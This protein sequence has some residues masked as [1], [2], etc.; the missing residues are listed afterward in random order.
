MR[1]SPFI[2][3]RF[4]SPEVAAGSR[5]W[6]GL[7]DLG[8]DDVDVDGEQAALFD[9]CHDGLHHRVAIAIGDGQHGVLHHVGALLV[10]LLELEGVE[11]GLVVV[12]APDVMDAAFAADQHLIDVEGRPR[13]GIVRPHIAFLMAAHAHAAAARAVRH[14][15]YASATF[16]SAALVR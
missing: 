13:S 11:R 6:A 1:R 10:G 8:R 7:A 9:C 14:C 3:V 2:E 12:A 4:I 15:R 5:T 16:T